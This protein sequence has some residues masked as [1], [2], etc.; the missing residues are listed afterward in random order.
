MYDGRHDVDILIGYEIETSS[1]G[2]LMQRAAHH[3]VN[4]S[5]QLS[6]V[7]TGIATTFSL[8][9]CSSVRL[10]VCLSVCLSVFLSATYCLNSSSVVV[11]AWMTE[12]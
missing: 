6:R 12:L 10:S 1:W 11:N 7:N 8:S 4:L 2:Y 3:N 9:V 5:S